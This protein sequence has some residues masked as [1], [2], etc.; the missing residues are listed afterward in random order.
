[1]RSDYGGLRT[2]NAQ[3]TGEHGPGVLAE[4]LKHLSYEVVGRRFLNPAV[5]ITP[6]R[7]EGFRAKIKGHASGTGSR[8]RA[9]NY[10]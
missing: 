8:T 9:P 3:G 4:V 5:Q 1:M 7:R 6:C 10:L 2:I